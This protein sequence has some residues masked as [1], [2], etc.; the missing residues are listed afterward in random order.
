MGEIVRI[1][2]TDGLVMASAI[3][4]TDIVARAGR[5]TTPAPPPPRPWAGRCWPAP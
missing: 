2:T 5:S 4:G 1:M 3:T